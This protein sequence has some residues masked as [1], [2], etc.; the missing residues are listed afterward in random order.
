MTN[1]TGQYETINEIT[2][3]ESG[4]S[5][6]SAATYQIT[7]NETTTCVAKLRDSLGEETEEVRFTIYIMPNTQGAI[8]VSYYSNEQIGVIYPVRLKG[9]NIGNIYGTDIYRASSSYIQ[10][11]AAHMG[12]ANVNESKDLFIKIVQSPEGR[13]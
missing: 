6:T 5:S 12:L 1:L 9:Y 10:R 11:S 8:Q 4:W 3:I 7:V 2:K 13:I